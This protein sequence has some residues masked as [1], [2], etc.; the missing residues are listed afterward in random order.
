MAAT[1]SGYTNALGPSV[2]YEYREGVSNRTDSSVRLLLE[3]RVKPSANISVQVSH[4]TR[5]YVEGSSGFTYRETVMKGDG[6]TW[7][8]GKWSGWMVVF[9]DNVPIGVDDKVLHLKTCIGANP[10]SYVEP[11][12]ALGGGI[13]IGVYQR[14]SKTSISSVEPRSIDVGAQN[15]KTVTVSWKAVSG[16]TYRVYVNTVAS[17]SGA[18]VVEANSSATSCTFNPKVHFAGGS[19]VEVPIGT[20]YYIGVETRDSSNVSASE[21]AWSAPIAYV[22]NQSFSPSFAKVVGWNGVD[23]EIACRGERN[24][25]LYYSGDHEGSYPI[26]RYV[27]VR[28]DGVEVEWSPSDV[29]VDSNGTYTLLDLGAWDV[30][31]DDVNFRVGAYDSRGRVLYARNGLQFTFDVRFYGGLLSVYDNGW[32]N[33]FCW[34]YDGFDWQR[35]ES[36]YVYT[37]TSWETMR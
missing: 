35:V 27:L 21:I 2:Q 3:M 32:R 8:A 10:F 26:V 23:N 7:D 1:L 15:H 33:G 30:Q 31:N 11:D 9:D 28:Q 4:G 18:K 37:G 12:D 14:P 5:A 29:K 34:V 25:K 22:G 13:D 17:A 6:L 24:V 19:S 16:S 36:V 20:Q